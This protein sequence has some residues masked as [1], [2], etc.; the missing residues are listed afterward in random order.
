MKILMFSWEYPPRNVGGLARHVY[1]LARAL[2]RQGVAIHVITVGED[3]L[4][5]YR[6]EAGVEVH[7]VRPYHLPA[8]DFRTWVLHLNLAMLEYAGRLLRAE[9]VDAVHAHDWLVA[10]AGRAVKHGWRLPLLATIHATERGRNQGLYTDEQR[11]ISDVEW[12]LT[13]EAWRV[14]VCSHYMKGELEGFFQVPADK[15]R[16]IPNGV[17]VEEFRYRWQDLEEVRRRYAPYGEKIVFFVGRLVQ[18]KGVHLLIEAAP[19][20][21]AVYPGTRFLIAGQGPRE[22]Y[23]KHLTFSRGLGDRFLFLGYVEDRV[24]DLLY[25]VADVAV[26][27]SLY[28]PFGIVALEAMALGTPVVVS[29]TGGFAEIVNHG[30]NGMKFYNGS[31]QSLADNVLTVLGS[32]ELRER[33]RAEGLKTVREKYSWDAV[34]RKTAGVYR[35]VLRE[36]SR[37]SWEEELPPLRRKRPALTALFMAA[38]RY[39][40]R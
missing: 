28:E 34:A 30:V 21:L 35:E 13:Y 32:A 18:E 38:G 33:L 24:R 8:P 14:I 16:V 11:Y 31:A 40:W 19:R 7:R 25:R 3:D 4:P 5:P 29:D 20:I 1:Y 2:V 22:E 15:I 10:Y 39:G 27:P 36:F 12:W 17:E 26:F 37:V 23:L 6:K 9:K